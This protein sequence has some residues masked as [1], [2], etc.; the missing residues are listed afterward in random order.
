MGEQ[1]YEC[2]HCGKCFIQSSTLNLHQ[3]VLTGERPHECSECGKAFFSLKLTL[4]PP[5][6]IN[7]EEKSY[8]CSECGKVFTHKS[9]LLKLQRVHTEGDLKPKPLP[10][11]VLG[12]SL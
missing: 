5:Q 3:R 2:I 9:S 12:K 1:P 6:R 4:T 7:N 8:R 10:S 11:L